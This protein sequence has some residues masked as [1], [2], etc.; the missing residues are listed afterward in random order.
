MTLKKRLQVGAMSL[1]CAAAVAAH[2]AAETPSVQASALSSDDA[3]RYVAAFRD[4]ERGDFIDAQ[5]HAADIQDKSLLGYLSFRQLMH[6]TAHKAA[7]EELSSWLTRFRDLPVAERIFALAAKRKPVAAADPPQPTL[8]IGAETARAAGPA[9][10]EGAQKARDAYFAGDLRRALELAPAAGERF[11]AGLAAW[12][13][14]AFDQAE[15]HFAALA[16]DEAQDPWTRAAGAF[17]AARAAEQLGEADHVRSFLRAAAQSP[18]TFY[19]MIAERRLRLASGAPA[20]PPSIDS[21]IRAAYRMPA[22]EV[23]AFM[24]ENDRAH[25][26]AAL[27]QIGR[28]QECGQEL[29]AGLALARSEDERARWAKLADVL[30]VTSDEPAAGSARRIRASLDYPTPDLQPRAGFTLDRALVYAIV[31]QE[32]GFNPDAVSPKGAVGLMQLMPEAAARAAG[33]DKLKSDTSPLFD[34]AF[35]LRVGQDYLTWLME[36]GT[37][38]D[39]LKVVA[40]YNGG[41]GLVAKTVQAVGAEA[42]DLLLIESIPA[43]ETRA[44]VQKVIAGY[45]TYRQLFGQETRTLDALAAGAREVDSRLDLANAGRTAQLATQPL[46][47]GMR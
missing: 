29:R 27:A 6:P 32:S 30:G 1:I 28:L 34:P 37:G 9:V 18:D 2:A 22:P 12:R 31:R 38:Y 20:A 47:V 36:R 26:A 40:A 25:R 45:W 3:D 16:R 24:R 14:R 43:F 44:Y 21:L 11:V 15:T 42:D 7:F 17:W 41:P 5:V 35:N 23:A 39:L 13:L 8:L 4:V 10:S 33:D 46:Q 19:G